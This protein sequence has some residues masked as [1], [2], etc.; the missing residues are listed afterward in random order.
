MTDVAAKVIDKVAD[1]FF[2]EKQTP[3]LSVG[4]YLLAGAIGV[5]CCISQVAPFS[6]SSEFIDSI[7][8]K[9]DLAQTDFVVIFPIITIAL[10]IV[11]LGIRKRM[12]RKFEITKEN[13]KP[14]VHLIAVEDMLDL[15][16]GIASLLFMISVFLQ[17][18]H[19]G[20]VFVSNVTLITYAWTAYKFLAFFYCR[21][22]NKNVQIINNAL[23]KY[24]D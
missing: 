20:I 4:C 17:M 23:T 12:L 11:C 14:F 10:Y 8:W 1:S 3:Y 9:G 22:A 13:Y 15:L 21:F 6:C 2:K 19:T 24:P 7:V 5:L 16:A 18:Y